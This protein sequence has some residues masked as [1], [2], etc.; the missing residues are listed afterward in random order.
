MRYQQFT[1]TEFFSQ[2]NSEEKARDFF[3]RTS[4]MVRTLS[5]L[6]VSM[7]TIISSNLDRK[8]GNVLHV[9]LRRD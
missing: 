5:A 2:I 3:W 4:L 8:S 1:I 6:D 7:T 9:E